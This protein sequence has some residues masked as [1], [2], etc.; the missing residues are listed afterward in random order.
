MKACFAAVMGLAAHSFSSSLKP[1][2][3]AAEAPAAPVDPATQPP[4]HPADFR[5]FKLINVHDETPNTKVYRFAY[6]SGVQ[7]Y[8]GRLTSCIVFK[9]TDKDGKDVMRPYT[10]ISRI[11]QP[12]YFEVM[13]KTYKDSKMGTHLSKMAIGSSIDVKGAYDKFLYKPGQFKRIGMLAGGTGITPMFQLIREIALHDAKTQPEMSLVYASRRKE[14]ILLGTELSELMEA[15]SNFAPYFVLSDPPRDW[16][17]GVGH[18]N[19]EMIKAFMPPPSAAGDSMVLVCGPPGFM[20]TISGDKDFSSYPPAQGE[21]TGLL[22]EMGYP[23]K[24]VFKF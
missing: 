13:V 2:A 19:K 12:G 10:P 14:D 20:K 7:K 5:P 3:Q 21:L 4:F 23:Q 15:R 1:A 16:M 22:A 6:P 9:F 18:V 24:M 8:N 17:G 11:D